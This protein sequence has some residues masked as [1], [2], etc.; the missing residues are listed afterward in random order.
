MCVAGGSQAAAW[1]LLFCH[2]GGRGGRGLPQIRKHVALRLQS[3]ADVLL[4]QLAGARQGQLGPQQHLVRQLVPEAVRAYMHHAWRTLILTSRRCYC[5]S[6]LECSLALYYT[7]STRVVPWEV[8]TS[9]ALL[10]LLLLLL[11]LCVV[12]CQKIIVEN[13]KEYSE[14]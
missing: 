5:S 13:E 8:P 14:Q 12:C 1:R 3:R 7:S 6:V 4:V 9:T 2:R 10:L 11:L